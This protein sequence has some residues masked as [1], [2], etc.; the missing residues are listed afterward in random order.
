ME[1]RYH[2]RLAKDLGY[3]PLEKF[4]EYEK[5]YHQVGSMLNAL[6]NSLDVKK[7]DG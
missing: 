2:L 6:I 1:T 5:A 7:I 3:L 4:K